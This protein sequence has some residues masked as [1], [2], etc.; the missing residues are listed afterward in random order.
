MDILK[1]NGIIAE[2]NPFHS[3]HK[4][5]LEESLRLTGAYHTVVVMS[6]NFVQRGAPALLD[7]YARAEAA[8]RCGADLVLELPVLYAAASAEYFAAGAVALLDSLG[9]VTHLCF[10]SEC[11]DIGQLCRIA[12][13]FSE[14]PEDYRAALKSFL[15]EGDSYP[16]ARAR[17]LALTRPSDLPENWEEILS[18]PNNILGIEYIRALQRLGS[19]IQPVT[20]KRLGAGYHDSLRAPESA[21]LSGSGLS[22]SA[23]LSSS[24]LSSCD[25]TS[26][27]ED[28]F[29]S[30]GIRLPESSYGGSTPPIRASAACG[31]SGGAHP[32]PCSALAIRQALRQDSAPAA[33]TPHMPPEAGQVFLS[34]LEKT[35]PLYPDDFS[36]ILYYR[37]LT[38]KK[39]GY[40]KY[41]D[42]SPDLSDRIRNML[43]AFTG[44]ESFCDLLKTKNMTH[45]RISRCLLHILLGIE[46]EHMELGQRLGHAPYARVL[47]FGRNAGP[48]LTAL[49]KHSRIPLVT[50]LA[51]AQKSLQADACRLLA[52]DIS[53]GEIYHC[54]SCEGT[55]Q[56]APNEFTTPLVIL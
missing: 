3:G 39:Y 37:L 24:G 36:S 12:H 41:L 1:I 22:E 18:S 38:E 51:D 20:V 7:K 55:G 21:C 11:G 17:A 53:A 25:G 9:A 29:G 46:K 49:K 23:C 16:G 4:Y 48:L 15:K 34:Q 32:L 50:K 52:L 42:L 30:A 28:S 45:S 44:Y 35:R 8:L 33:L 6:G 31:H 19:Q 13:A 26:A 27:P 47:G 2:Y 14:E 43:G 54:I 5:Q 10:G 56:P 40:E